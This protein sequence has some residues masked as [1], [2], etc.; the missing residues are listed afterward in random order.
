MHK[1]F[2]RNESIVFL[3]IETNKKSVVEKEYSMYYIRCTFVSFLALGNSGIFSKSTVR[4]KNVLPS[5]VDFLH[6]N[7]CKPCYLPLFILIKFGEKSKFLG[8]FQKYQL[9]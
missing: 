7:L 8:Y 3:M 9:Y 6:A 5:R 4:R 2:F 1:Y